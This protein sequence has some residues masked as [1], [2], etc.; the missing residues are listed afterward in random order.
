[1]KKIQKRIRLKEFNYIGT[2]RYFVTICVD[3]KRNVFVNDDIVNF[4]IKIMRDLSERY[5]FDIWV[6]CFMPDHLHI[7]CEGR[8]E[9]SNFRKFISVFKQ[10]SSYYVVRTFKF[11]FC[12]YMTKLWQENY[13]DRVL[14]KEENIIDVVKYILNNPVRNGLVKEYLDYPYLGSFKLDVK[15]LL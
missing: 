12:E 7:L 9:K 10:K 8:D 13:F 1:M 14:R 11:A 4:C 5:L 15:D 3:R 6:Y 2:Y